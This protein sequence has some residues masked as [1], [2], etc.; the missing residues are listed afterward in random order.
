MDH[1]IEKHLN[2]GRTRILRCVSLLLA[3]LLAVVP[4]GCGNRTS[5]PAPP[6]QSAEAAPVP[7][8]EPTPAQTPEPVPTPEPTPAPNMEIS[9][10]APFGEDS[11]TEETLSPDEIG[12]YYWYWDCEMERGSRF[13]LAARCWHGMPRRRLCRVRASLKAVCRSDNSQNASR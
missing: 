2:N 5:E 10:A 9:L 8:A 7:T 13:C 11:L 1:P 12:F 3:V 6:L 4:V